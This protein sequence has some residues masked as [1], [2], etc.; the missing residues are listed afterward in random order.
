M[1]PEQ[2][3]FD[4]L[5]ARGHPRRHLLPR[6]LLHLLLHVEPNQLLRLLRR[7]AAL[8]EVDGSFLGLP[9]FVGGALGHRVEGTVAFHGSQIEIILVTAILSLGEGINV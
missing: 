6:R 2:G 5:G 9:A 8:D 1:E 3:I 4:F 7:F